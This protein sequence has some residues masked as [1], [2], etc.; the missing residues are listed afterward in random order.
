[1]SV[2]GKNIVCFGEVLWDVY[3]DGKELGG[4]PFNVAAHMKKLGANSH[5]V[6]KVGREEL[7]TQIIRAIEEQDISTNYTQIDYTFSTGTV[8][9]RLD[10]DGKP[11][12]HVKQPSAWDFIHSNL[13][14]M[15]LVQNSSALIFGTL[16]CRS[17]RS[18]Q[19][20]IDLARISK[21]N[22]CDLNIRQNYYSKELIEELLG[23]TDILKINEEELRLI[24]AIFE[25]DLDQNLQKLKEKFDLNLIILTKGA[26]GAQVWF[27]DRLYSAEA[28]KVNVIDTVGSGD[29]FLAAFIHNYLNDEKIS[30]CLE[31]GCAL[32][33]YV[34]S[35]PG[36][37]PEH[38]SKNIRA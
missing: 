19:T 25:I 14:N 1:M 10:K 30:H 37:I 36:A 31:S 2:Q 32:G 7:G 33:A 21:L 12:Y 6:T 13:E 27:E 20:L 38:P 9:V 11:T 34:A 3:P 28:H 18:R 26:E 15:N 16:A 23:F 35:K 5:I 22:I 29:A 8:D 17:E 24:E 4:A